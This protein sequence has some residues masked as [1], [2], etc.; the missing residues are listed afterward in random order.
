MRRAGAYRV[1]QTRRPHL[2]LELVRRAVRISVD[3]FYLQKCESGSLIDHLRTLRFT[4]DRCNVNDHADVAAESV[5]EL[6]RVC[7]LHGPRIGAINGLCVYMALCH[8]LID[9]SPSIV[10]HGPDPRM[11]AGT[12]PTLTIP[13]RTIPTATIPTSV[14]I[15][16]L[17]SAYWRSPAHR[18]TCGTHGRRNRGVQGVHVPPTFSGR[19]VQ[20]GTLCESL[21]VS[22]CAVNGFVPF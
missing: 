5:V 3:R 6:R 19:G 12:I 13:T 9:K 16:G 8:L 1:G 20:E 7:R 21:C 14:I 11:G 17:L 15:V 10:A 4:K 22:R 18:S 2:L